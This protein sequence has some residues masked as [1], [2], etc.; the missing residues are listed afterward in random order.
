MIV[1]NNQNYFTTAELAERYACSTQTIRRLAKETNM[2]CVKIGYWKYFE[3]EAAD[4][5]LLQRKKTYAE[6]TKTS[7]RIV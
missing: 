1:I 7:L 5:C 6:K 2:A 3:L 4:Y